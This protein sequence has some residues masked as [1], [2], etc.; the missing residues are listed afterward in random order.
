[1]DCKYRYLRINL[2]EAS[3]LFVLLL[4]L[5][6]AM[7]RAQVLYG[8]ISGNVTDNSGAVISNGSV[9]AVNVATGTSRT[10]TTNSEGIYQ[11]QDLQPGTYTVTVTATGFAPFKATGVQ[12]NPNQITRSDAQLVVG[13]SQQAIE[14][15]S[16]SQPVL[17]TD[18]ADVNTEINP[19]QLAELPTTSSYGRNFQSLYK[20]VPGFTP[21]SEQNSSGGNP[22][23]IGRP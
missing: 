4:T 16:A 14:V 20:L 6:T 10:V 9:T 18:K 5:S 13:T 12:V 15:N 23:R 19:V 11:I 21:P 7:A 22:M 3:A 17:Q 2:L 1:M 8:T